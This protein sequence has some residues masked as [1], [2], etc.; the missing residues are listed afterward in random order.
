L[1]DYECEAQI[2]PNDNPLEWWK[3]KQK[4]YPILSQLERKFLAI[5][6]SSVPCERLFSSAGNIITQKRNRLEPNIAAGLIMMYE[7]A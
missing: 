7:N 1:E 5:P 2:H 6:A 4:K 3:I